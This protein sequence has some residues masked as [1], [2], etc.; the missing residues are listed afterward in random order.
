MLT[1]EHMQGAAHDVWDVNKDY[2]YHEELRLNGQ[3]RYH[4]RGRATRRDN[5][6]DRS[7]VSA[8]APSY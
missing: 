1:V 6:N 5:S 7:R 2:E 4:G 3:P 8:Q